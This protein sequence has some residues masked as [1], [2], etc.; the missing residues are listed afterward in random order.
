MEGI[1]QV[2][3]GDREHGARHGENDR[4]L[5]LEPLGPEVPSGFRVRK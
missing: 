4:P 2:V 1:D 3:L 5:C